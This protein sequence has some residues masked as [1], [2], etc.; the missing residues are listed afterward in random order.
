MTWVPL[1]DF[2]AYYQLASV[3]APAS[4]NYRQIITFNGHLDVQLAV[5]HLAWNIS[6]AL[7]YNETSYL[8]QF[9]SVC[10]L[11]VFICGGSGATRPSGEGWERH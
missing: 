11:D 6:S 7:N 8:E 1:H 9:V 2:F 10:K 4:M 3:E 5:F